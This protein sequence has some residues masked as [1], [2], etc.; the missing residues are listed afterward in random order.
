MRNLTEIILLT[1]KT[2][3]NNIIKKYVYVLFIMKERYHLSETEYM[4]ME[5]L[6]TE[7]A[8]IKQTDLLSYFK[9]NGRDWSRQTLNTIVSRL[10]ERGFVSRE[11]RFVKAA[12]SR[13]DFGFNIMKE[14]V[15]N[16]YDGKPDTLL[17]A[18]AEKRKITPEQAKRLHEMVERINS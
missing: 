8:P 13:H 4:I 10:E 7:G 1:N 3:W 17:V 6:W 14:A 15:D 16:Y 5:K 9:L 12:L 11:N 2:K 18:L